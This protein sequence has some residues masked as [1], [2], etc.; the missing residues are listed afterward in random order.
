MGWRP[1]STFSVYGHVAYQIKGHHANTYVVLTYTLDS[2]SGVKRSKLFFLK[3]VMLHIKLKGMECKAPCKHI[4]C[5]YAHP[6]PVGPVQKVKLFFL[7][8]VVML[9]I[10]LKGKK[11]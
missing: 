7:L 11:Y 8:N 6:R 1:N 3:V 4:F 10:K 5:P 9:H 2:E